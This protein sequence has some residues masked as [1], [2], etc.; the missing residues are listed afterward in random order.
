[1][2]C[3]AAGRSPDGSDTSH[4]SRDTDSSFWLS[5]TLFLLTEAALVEE[6]S[7]SRF[8]EENVTTLCYIR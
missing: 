1:M 8:P 7:S 3:A 4:V 6:Y 5:E 2:F